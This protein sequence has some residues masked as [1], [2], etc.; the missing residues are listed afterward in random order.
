MDDTAK[1][2]QLHKY[3]A[4]IYLN[5]NHET[6]KKKIRS[7][8]QTRLNNFMYKCAAKTANNISKSWSKPNTNNNQKNIIRPR[9]AKYTSFKLHN[10]NKRKTHETNMMVFICLPLRLFGWHAELVEDSL[11]FHNMSNSKHF[12]L[13]KHACSRQIWLTND[14][15]HSLAPVWQVREWNMIEVHLPKTWSMC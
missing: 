10:N 6:M 12:F 3:P 9:P 1:E 14:K 4:R 15:P 13:I 7:D 5:R 11:Q 2:K 8:G